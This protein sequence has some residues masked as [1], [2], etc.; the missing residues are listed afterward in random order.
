MFDFK[1]ELATKS[2]VDLFDKIGNF[3]KSY[4]I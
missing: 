1:K 3:L 4:P 2:K